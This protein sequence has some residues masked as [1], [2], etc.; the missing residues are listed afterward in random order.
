M[1]NKDYVCLLDLNYRLR[2]VNSYGIKVYKAGYKKSIC[3]VI[4]RR[5][6]ILYPLVII[7]EIKGSLLS[8]KVRVY[9]RVIYAIN[10][11]PRAPG[12]V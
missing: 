1:K 7:F 2:K 3:V 5:F 6:G 11:V 8:I 10:L 4:L 12:R 9:L